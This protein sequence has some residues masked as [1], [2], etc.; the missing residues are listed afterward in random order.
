MWSFALAMA[1]FPD[2]QRTAQAEIDRVIGE[3]RLPE[4]ED[5]SM[6]P[7]VTA[8]MRE[9]LRSVF[10]ASNAAHDSK[11]LL[12]QGGVPLDR[13]VSRTPNESGFTSLYHLTGAPHKLLVDDEYRGYHIPAGT[14]VLG[15]SWYASTRRSDESARTDPLHEQGD[16]A[17]RED[18]PPS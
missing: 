14:T 17:R 16:N 10:D 4:H 7:Y 2:V 8:V 18:M 11:M 5:Q 15:N 6:L 9:T 12:I 1:L 13:L 3:D